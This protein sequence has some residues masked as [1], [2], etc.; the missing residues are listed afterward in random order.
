M[1]MKRQQKLLEIKIYKNGC[2]FPI[3]N[4]ITIFHD[5]SAQKPIFILT[6]SNWKHDKT[7]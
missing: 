6:N 3:L 1:Q 4:P 2:T 7:S 5:I